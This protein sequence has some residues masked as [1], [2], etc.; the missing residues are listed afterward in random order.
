MMKCPTCGR[1]MVKGAVISSSS[2][3]FSTN[4]MFKPDRNDGSCT[5]AL[6]NKAEAYVCQSCGHDLPIIRSDD[7]CRLHPAGQA[8][9]VF[10]RLTL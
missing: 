9:S 7:H 1:D 2:M 3:P 8:L 4:V 6:E 10:W 5:L